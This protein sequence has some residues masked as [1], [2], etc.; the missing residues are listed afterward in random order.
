MWKDIKKKT[1]TT[2]VKLLSQRIYKGQKDTVNNITMG[3]SSEKSVLWISLEK[4]KIQGAVEEVRGNL[5]FKKDLWEL[6]LWLSRLRT[7]LVSMRIQVQFLASLSGL[8]IWHYHELWLGSHIAVAVAS[9]C[10]SNSTPSPE[11]FHMLQV[12]L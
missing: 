6:L 5:Q 10:S 11:I 4:K 2:Q 8:R 3:I 7:R 9:S 1:E 12:W